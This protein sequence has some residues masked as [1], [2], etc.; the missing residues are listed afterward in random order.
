[1]AYNHVQEH[2]ALNNLMLRFAF[3]LIMREILRY[4]SYALLI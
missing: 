4:Q 3:H 2:N 1:M